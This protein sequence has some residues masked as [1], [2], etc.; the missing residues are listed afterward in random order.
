L[1]PVAEVNN[2]GQGW[3]QLLISSL[4]STHKIVLE[5]QNRQVTYILN[6]VW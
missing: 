6:F 4:V 5:E 2:E 1:R 3:C